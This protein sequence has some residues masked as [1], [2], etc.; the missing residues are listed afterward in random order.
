[1]FKQPPLGPLFVSSVIAFGC[2]ETLVLYRKRAGEKAMGRAMVGTAR[3]RY[4]RLKE[5][6]S[7]RYGI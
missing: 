7:R 2:P 6:A 4:S 3:F 1:M 5:A